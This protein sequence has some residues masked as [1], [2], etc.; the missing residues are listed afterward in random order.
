LAALEPFD[1][2]CI[3]DDAVPSVRFDVSSVAPRCARIASC[4]FEMEPSA[5]AATSSPLT[6]GGIPGGDRCTFPRPLSSEDFD[7]RGELAATVVARDE[8]GNGHRVDYL[9]IIPRFS[10]EVAGGSV[11]ARANVG[12]GT[13]SFSAASPGVS[14][15]PATTRMISTTD[16]RRPELARSEDVGRAR[17]S[18][19]AGVGTG[20]VRVTYQPPGACSVPDPLEIQVTAEGS[21]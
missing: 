18:L 5:A 2:A 13:F 10:V 3:V 9:L 11:E 6:I 1:G 16:R 12:G 15:G 7:P 21:P 4:E 20:T 14:I 19:D 8:A 17:V